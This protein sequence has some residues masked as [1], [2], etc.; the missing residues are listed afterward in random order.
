MQKKQNEERGIVDGRTS[1]W[2]HRWRPP[3]VTAIGSMQSGSPPAVTAVDLRQSAERRAGPGRISRPDSSPVPPGPVS[4]SPSFLSPIPLP[5]PLRSPSPSFSSS[6]LPLS[7]FLLLSCE[8]IVK[9][10]LKSSKKAK[11][12]SHQPQHHQHGGR[13]PEAN[14]PTKKKPHQNRYPSQASP[15][16]PTLP[17]NWDQHEEEGDE[18]D[19]YGSGNPFS[20]TPKQEIVVPKSKGA[21]YS[22]L[23]SE[24]QSQPRGVPSFHEVILQ[25]Q[26][27][28]EDGEGT[29]ILHVYDTIFQGLSARMTAE[30]AEEM[31]KNPAVLKDISDGVM[32]LHTRAGLGLIFGGQARY[33][34]RQYYGPGLGFRAD[35]G[36]GKPGRAGPIPTPKIN[37]SY[38]IIR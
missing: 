13:K 20:Q 18:M 16:Q 31:G 34:A 38:K 37:Q 21:D 23:I 24:A 28:A 6:P 30:E 12:V 22:Y 1:V 4:L 5:P 29:G 33:P 2:Y 9:M 17:S 11:G 32:R 26:V 8:G 27:A 10:D 3:A 7:L 15:I 36:R 35:P 14:K 19:E 25:E